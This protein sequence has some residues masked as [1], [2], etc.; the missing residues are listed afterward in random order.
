MEAL[1]PWMHLAGRVLFSLVFI[2][3]GMNHLM[4][5]D[6]MARYAQSKGVPAPKAAIVLSGIVIMLGGL[7]IALGWH[8]F[9]GAGLLAIFLVFTP[10]MMHQFWKETDPTAKANEMA[11]FLK[12][13]ALAGAALVIAYYAGQAWPMSLGG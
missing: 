13:T 6:N 4:Q 12:D 11:H 9:I 7:S 10:V 8:R 2:M 5:L 1:Y 3:S